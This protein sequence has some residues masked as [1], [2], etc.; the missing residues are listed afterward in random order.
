MTGVP[1]VGPTHQ[2]SSTDEQRCLDPDERLLDV[3][4]PPTNAAYC[5]ISMVTLMH[6]DSLIIHERLLDVVSPTPTQTPTPLPTPLHSAPRE[7]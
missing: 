7:K 6:G 4:S 5:N 2:V 1:C 3:V